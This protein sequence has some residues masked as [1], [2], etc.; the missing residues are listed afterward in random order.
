M[1]RLPKVSGRRARAAFER[2]GFSFERQTGSHMILAKPGHPFTLAV[3][4]HREMRDGTLRDL[5]RKSGLTVEEF[6]K[7]LR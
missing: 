4:D 5:I 6:T 2:V 3:P 1:P 7:L